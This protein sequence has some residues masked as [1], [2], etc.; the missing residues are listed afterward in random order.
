MS[1]PFYTVLTLP[2][3]LGVKDDHAH[4]RAG[5]LIGML[6]AFVALGHAEI[7]APMPTEVRMGFKSPDDPAAELSIYFIGL[8]QDEF[9]GIESALNVDATG[10]RFIVGDITLLDES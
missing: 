2:T 7:N 8:L 6:H 5:M 9:G 4:G 1:F 10:K 3:P